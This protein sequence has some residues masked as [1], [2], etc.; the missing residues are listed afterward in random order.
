MNVKK[1]QQSRQK[2]YGD[3][4]GG[5]ILRSKIMNLITKRYSG[6]HGK[7]M[8][9]TQESMIWD[10]VNK[11]TRIAVTPT[12]VDS[13]HDLSSYA[14]LIEETLKGEEDARK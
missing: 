2:V 10:I 4:G 11:L 5:A 12:H 3:Y 14:N 13:W 6:L 7:R 8:P 9:S 1:T